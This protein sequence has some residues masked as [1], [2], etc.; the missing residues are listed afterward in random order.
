[1]TGIY[2]CSMI[3]HMHRHNRLP[4][5][6]LDI[7]HQINNCFWLIIASIKECRVTELQIFRAKQICWI[8]QLSNKRKDFKF[9]WLGAQKVDLLAAISTAANSKQHERN[10]NE[11]HIMSKNTPIILKHLN[12]CLRCRVSLAELIQ[13]HHFDLCCALQGNHHTHCLQ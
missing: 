13:A 1:M 10:T 4:F 7:K 6:T 9:I 3:C 12:P 2:L 5:L 8:T 11:A